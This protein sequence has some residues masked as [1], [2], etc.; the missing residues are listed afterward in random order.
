MDQLASLDWEQLAAERAKSGHALFGPSSLPRTMRCTGSTRLCIESG[1]VPIETE[2]AIEGSDAHALAHKASD[3]GT[4][5]A[6]YAG[7]EVTY[8]KGA[9]LRSFTPDEDMCRHVQDYLD[10]C[11]ELPGEAFVESTVKLDK[12]MPLPH[13]FGTA[14]HAAIYADTLIITDFKY[15]QGEQVFAKDNEQLLAYAL[16]FYLEHGWMYD[17]RKVV[18]RICQPRLNHFD[19]WE[20]TVGE[21]ELFGQRM[22]SKIKEAISADAKLIAGEKQCRF[23][24]MS[25]RCAAQKAFVDKLVAADFDHFDDPQDFAPALSYEQ[26]GVALSN[27]AVVK[28][29]LK[30]LEKQAFDALNRDIEVPGWKM[31][32]GRA[33]R[34]WIDE[35]KAELWLK[36]HKLKPAHIYVKSM[37]S[38]AQAEKLFKGDKKKELATLVRK[39]PGRPVL[40]PITD[41]RPPYTTLA[42]EFASGF[43]SEEDD[44]DDVPEVAEL[45]T[46]D[47]L[48]D[49]GDGL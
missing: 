9:E 48:G 5:V 36:I 7:R 32:E 14:D 15:G 29:W 22:Y 3:T 20:T 2:Y 46:N 42:G 49:D 33:N 21:L 41:R 6:L 26:L 18:C 38:P 47:G 43:E 16:G 27:R 24:P 39:P 23:C 10:W 1:V 34:T 30:G 25:G 13:Q 40:A 17:L 8:H 45:T 35:K 11:A 28:Q 19:V 37:I 12:Y 4:D 44:D 31:V